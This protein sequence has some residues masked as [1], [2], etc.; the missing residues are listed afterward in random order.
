MNR[1]QCLALASSV[2][3]VLLLGLTLVSSQADDNGNLGPFPDPSGMISTVTPSGKLDTSNPFFKSL[4][5]N[6]RSCGSCHRATDAWSVTPEHLRARF[7]ATQG[8][9]PIF[10][11]VDGSNSPLADVSTLAARRTA[12]SMLLNRGVI[13][14]GLGIPATAEYSLAAVDD[15]YH[16]ASAK[17][18]SLF[19][20]PLP[21]TNLRF[22]T[23]IMWD[24]R[25]TSLPFLP[26]M[27]PGA[28]TTDL[29][30]SLKQ[31]A[32]HAIL[33][34]AQG[35]AA[36]SEAQVDE[37]VAFEMGL[38]TAQI[39]DNHAGFLNA[40]DA[41][42]GPRILANHQFFL[43]INDTLGAD[44]TGAVFNPAA[45]SLFSAWGSPSGDSDD[46][47]NEEGT[48]SSE[49]HAVVRGEK[50]FNTRAIEITGVGGLNDSLNLTV[51]HGTCTTCHSSPNIGNH[52]VALPINIGLTDASRR[53]PDMPL[54]TLR[55]N[56]TGA[57]VQ[58]TDPGRA[59]I[60]GKWKDIG[61]FK[62][63]VL[64]GLAARAPYFHNGFAAGL[65]DVVEFYN[66]RFTMG[67]TRQEKS[68]LVAF[69][70]S[71]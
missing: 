33:G 8:L 34:H 5:S 37:I 25:E 39:F 4:G 60:T 55:N 45:M 31:Q 66:T 64:R 30:D 46:D 27:D 48:G 42:G 6:G 54:Y 1:T 36:P 62:G 70:R 21:S 16:F 49:R 13:R 26:P 65:Q 10:R 69:L 12:Y 57:E 68:D 7:E 35:S 58:T 18:L 71:L 56:T 17:E 44:P 3:T 51:I 29:V 41:L 59:L 32:V 24:G 38:T 67:L 47:G 61:K 23:G 43:G 22:L 14:I 20:R 2:P 52:S 15:P 9:D 11:P 40:F 63:P 50:L 19:R 53:T 28:N